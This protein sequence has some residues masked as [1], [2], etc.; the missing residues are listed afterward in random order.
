MVDTIYVPL[1][2]LTNEEKKEIDFARIAH[3][4][5]YEEIIENEFDTKLLNFRD[6]MKRRLRKLKGLYLIIEPNIRV[7]RLYKE[8]IRCYI[9]DLCDACSALCRAVVESVATEYCI[10]DKEARKKISGAKKNEKRWLLSKI[11]EKKLTKELYKIYSDI[12][13]EG[14]SVLHWRRSKV[15]EDEALKIIEDSQKFINEIY[16]TPDFSHLIEDI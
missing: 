4:L 11:L 1:T 7:V 8:I 16:K 3:S 13:L 9:F 15:N 6:D 2:G 5:G 12:G 10:Q 14:S